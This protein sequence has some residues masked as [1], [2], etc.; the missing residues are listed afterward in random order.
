[1]RYFKHNCITIL[2]RHQ[3]LPAPL[4]YEFYR[5]DAH[6][7]VNRHILRNMRVS[8]TA[9]RTRV[10]FNRT[11]LTGPGSLKVYTHKGYT[12]CRRFFLFMPILN[13]GAQRTFT[14]TLQLF[15]TRSGDYVGERDVTGEPPPLLDL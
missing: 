8:R 11:I 15:R 2:H 10:K 5:I 9:A 7:R 3:Y 13:C 1:M 4:V 6:I 14:V 12:S